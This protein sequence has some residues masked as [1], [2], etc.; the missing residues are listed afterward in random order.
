[1]GKEHNGVQLK[2]RL[3]PMGMFWS[4]PICGRGI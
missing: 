4:R 1:M 2:E 3:M